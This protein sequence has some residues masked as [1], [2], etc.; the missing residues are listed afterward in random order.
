M[1]LFEN[2]SSGKIL[3]YKFNLHENESAGGTHFKRN[4]L[5]RR[6]VLTQRQKAITRKWRIDYVMSFHRYVA[7]VFEHVYRHKKKVSGYKITWAPAVLRH[8][9]AHLEPIPL[10]KSTEELGRDDEEEIDDMEDFI[11]RVRGMSFR[12]QSFQFL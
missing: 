11:S 8:F 7:E 12:R 10:S 2:E 9:S 1:P 6:L 3:S 4:C 5:A